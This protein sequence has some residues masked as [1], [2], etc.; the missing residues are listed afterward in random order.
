MS[1]EPVLAPV[2]RDP[3]KIAWQPLGLDGEAVVRTV[4]G[5]EQS[6]TLGA[7]LGRFR[8]IEFEWKLDYDEVIH[9]LS[10]R[11]EVQH[12][13]GV[14]RGGPGDVVFV[15]AGNTVTYRFLGDCRLFFATYPVDW[16]ERASG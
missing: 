3:E 11:V 7:G 13:G 14:E 9:V 4:I 10:G 2:A 16:E 1:T 6:R 15:P 8:D 5:P 12:A